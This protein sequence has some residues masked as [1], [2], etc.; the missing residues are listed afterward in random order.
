M[1]GNGKRG[2]Y[3]EDEAELKES[4]MK[5]LDTI[6]C[7][8]PYDQATVKSKDIAA[9]SIILLFSAMIRNERLGIKNDGPRS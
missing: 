3:I 2:M 1:K 7:S 4:I 6:H 8:D 9:N 5:I